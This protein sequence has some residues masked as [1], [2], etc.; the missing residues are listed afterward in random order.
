MA[1]AALIAVTKRVYLVLIGEATVLLAIAAY[2]IWFT[3]PAS[4]GCMGWGG[5]D[6]GLIIY[7]AICGALACFVPIFLSR[8]DDRLGRTKTPSHS[9]RRSPPDL[10]NKPGSMQQS[11]PDR[12]DKWLDDFLQMEQLEKDEAHRQT[13]S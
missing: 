11:E 7:F 9:I 13:E 12:S 2:Y 5:S 4:R 10:S 1:A 6:Q 3:E 8:S